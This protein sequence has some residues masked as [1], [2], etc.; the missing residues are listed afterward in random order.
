MF[1]RV[2][3]EEGQGVSEVDF[4]RLGSYPQTGFEHL[5][6]DLLTAGLVYAGF[7]ATT[8]DTVSVQLAPGRIYENGKMFASE[9]VQER[10][11]ASYVPI[12][13]GQSVICLI[14]GQGQEVSDDL[15]NRYYER[16]I[17]VQNPDAGTQQTV[18]DA[19]RTKNRKAVLTVYPGIEGARP[20]APIAPIGS[21]A[22]AEVLITTSGI[23]SVT[24]RADTAAVRLDQQAAMIAAL[25]EGMAVLNQNLDGLRADQA[26]VKAQLMSSASR[27]ALSSLQVDMALLKDQL[28][29]SDDGSPYWSDRFLDYGE[30]DYDPETATGHVDFDALVEEGIRFNH[31]GVNE[32]PLSLYNPND[33]N[34]SHAANGLI[35][36]KYTAVEGI[37]VKAAT[38][39]MPLGGLSVQTITVEHLTEKRERIRYGK[40][41]NICNNSA[42]WKSGKYD[43][44]KGVFTAANG[45]TYKAAPLLS[46]YH[47]GGGQ[48]YQHLRLQ[49]FWTDTISVPY[50]KFKANETTIAGVVKAQTF[51]VHQE[52]WTPRL[53]LAIKRWGVGAAITAVLVECRT[54]G[55]PDPTRAL[56]S[57][58]KT[59]ADFKT[60]P[61]KSYFTFDKPRFL[62]PLEGSGGRARPFAV[63][64]FCT[65]DVDVATADGSS[66]L[67]GNLFTTTDGVYFDGDLTKDIC[68]GIDHCSFSITQMPIRLQ[69]WNLV[70]GI[71]DIDILATAIV[72]S[73]A[74]YAY[75]INVGGNW[76]ALSA[77]NSDANFINGVT[78]FYD[79]RVVLTG[80]QW[81][82]PI[83]EMT[84]SRVRLTRPKTAFKWISSAWA[85]GEA[86][87]SITLRAS[88]ASWDAAR[89]TLIAKCLSG[90]GFATTVVSGPV[91]TR[92]VPG[93]EVGRPDQE[94]AVEME[95][96]FTL[97]TNP[98]TVKFRLEATTDNARIPFL[99]EWA[100]ARKSA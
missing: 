83:I 10:S 92:V 63:M 88:V 35:C 30:T 17:D 46:G 31:A 37:A 2:I 62:S 68:F 26:G 3:V 75:E 55:T 48:T 66:F 22:I 36:P 90:A 99:I 25:V 97:P 73:S 50:D 89:H 6:R 38:G 61:A 29:I 40:S 47:T 80:T 23:Q 12:T 18:D 21:V 33:P 58:T 20:V 8:S 78:A 98:T 5:G 11:V 1:K 96:T 76:R 59:A 49:Q 41:K 77:E 56:A 70:G 32:Q 86:A 85:I 69:G 4:E 15:E 39:E 87:G 93:R 54:D 42:F 72:P 94:L 81:G 44:I 65:G 45:D 19:Y 13:A 14:V 52:R 9:T 7:T 27:N 34:L 82:M 43:P 79:T 24:M 53:W 100:A 64:F 84:D 60:W 67:G 57:V 95:W 74:N 16:P 71:E 51:L 28:D 91:T